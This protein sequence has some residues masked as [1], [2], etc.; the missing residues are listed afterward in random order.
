[1]SGFEIC[2]PCIENKATRK[3]TKL[4]VNRRAQHG[5]GLRLEQEFGG[6]EIIHVKV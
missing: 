4:Q 2:D 6:S 3:K 5:I 1:M